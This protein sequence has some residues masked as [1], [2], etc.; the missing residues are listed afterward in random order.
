MAW[1]VKLNFLPAPNAG[2]ADELPLIEM[3]E[4]QRKALWKMG[5]RGGG[6]FFQSQTEDTG[7]K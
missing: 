7:S 4:E 5:G 1:L 6:F 3:G 2:A